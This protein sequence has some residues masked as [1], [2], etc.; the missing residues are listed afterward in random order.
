L[1]VAWLVE[2][3]WQW[4]VRVGRES[5]EVCPNASIELSNK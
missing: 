2:V 1:W 5:R 3:Y 4:E